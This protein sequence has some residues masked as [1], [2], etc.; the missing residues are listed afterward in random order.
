[1][2]DENIKHQPA[3]LEVAEEDASVSTSDEALREMLGLPSMDGLAMKVEDV[4]SNN[5]EPHTIDYLHGLADSE[6]CRFLKEAN[7][8]QDYANDSV[9]IV[10]R[11]LCLDP[12]FM[13]RITDELSWGKYPSDKSFE[14]IK[15]AT[16]QREILERRTITRFENF[17]E[18]HD[19]WKR[20]TAYI[21]RLAS[22]I[23]QQPMVLFK[24]K[25]N[26]KPPG[27]SGFAPH[28]DTPSLRV[29]L[30]ERGPQNFVTVM[31][32]IDSMTQQNG[33]LQCAKGS[34][35][36]WSEENAVESIQPQSDGN[37]DGDGRAGAIPM[38]VAQTLSFHPLECPGGTVALFNGWTPHRSAANRSPFSRRAV[39]LTYNPLAEGEC[40]ELYYEHMDRLR[41]EFRV[42]AA[43]E[44]KR[45]EQAE[46]DALATIPKI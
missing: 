15:V 2:P 33:C 37:P 22:I 32:A 29:A 31:I 20:L 6:L 25:L 18:T 10:P 42:K 4:K 34:T 40:R 9:C 5:D 19:E 8:I 28:L 27:G 45:D 3:V 16:R 1:M 41:S 46:L 12:L 44:R 43:L 24:E 13:R 38:Q 36:G 17:V 14:T 23:C 39:F 11:G 35:T 7:S 26:L 21:G 30:A